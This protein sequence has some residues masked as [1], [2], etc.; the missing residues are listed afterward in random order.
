M[1]TLFRKTVFL[2]ADNAVKLLHNIRVAALGES[3]Q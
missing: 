2:D 1:V 3:R